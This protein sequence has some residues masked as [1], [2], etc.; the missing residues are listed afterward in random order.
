MAPIKQG[1]LPQT[2]NIQKAA[3]LGSKNKEEEIKNSISGV[4]DKV[5]QEDKWMKIKRNER[6]ENERPSA[7]DCLRPYHPERIRARLNI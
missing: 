6:K 2:G 4:K 1:Q 5:E 7:S 3:F